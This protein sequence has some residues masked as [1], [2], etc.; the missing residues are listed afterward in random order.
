MLV[1]SAPDE[2]ELSSLLDRLDSTLFRRAAF[3]VS[4][5]DRDIGEAAALPLEGRKLHA[6][7]DWGREEM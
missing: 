1:I 2:R 4:D 5:A 3:E 7:T 6:H